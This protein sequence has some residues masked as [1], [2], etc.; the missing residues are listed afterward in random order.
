MSPATY[1]LVLSAI[2]ALS[3]A[4]VVHI[5]Q[6]ASAAAGFELLLLLISAPFVAVGVYI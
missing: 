1:L 4:A 5:F 6:L 2:V 3:I